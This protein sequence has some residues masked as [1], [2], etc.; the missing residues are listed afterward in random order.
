MHFYRNDAY[1]NSRYDDDKSSVHRDF[2]LL[3][4]SPFYRK[5]G[6]FG[7]T[8]DA[9]CC[10]RHCVNQQQANATDF[11]VLSV[12]L[13]ISIVDNRSALVSFRTHVLLAG[14]LD[15]RSL[16]SRCFAADHNSAFYLP[17]CLQAWCWSA[18]PAAA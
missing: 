3:V 15:S 10:A 1:R 4:T 12:K 7:A 6:L 13:L 5:H 9:C 2:S 8:Q 18:L 16:S 14:G 17:P 11:W